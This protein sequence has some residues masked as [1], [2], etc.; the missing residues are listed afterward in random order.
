M[1]MGPIIVALDLDAGSDDVLLQGA[2]L[3]DWT[4]A[5]LTVLQVVQNI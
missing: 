5:P 2:R 1:A 3:A 4:G